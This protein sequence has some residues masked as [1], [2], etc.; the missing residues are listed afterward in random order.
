MIYYEFARWLIPSFMEINTQASQTRRQGTKTQIMQFGDLVIIYL[1]I[2]LSLDIHKNFKMLCFREE[3]SNF[4]D[5]SWDR[6]PACRTL[7]YL[8][9]IYAAEECRM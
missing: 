3:V 1:L 7:H 9:Q 2:W 6:M 8:Q 4:L 5:L